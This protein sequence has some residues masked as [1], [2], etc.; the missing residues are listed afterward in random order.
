MKYM[1]LPS[2]FNI[3]PLIIRANVIDDDI[4]TAIFVGTKYEDMHEI[5]GFRD[6]SRAAAFI[7][8]LQAWSEVPDI[9]APENRELEITVKVKKL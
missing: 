1:V 9:C 8:E 6:P 2:E 5:T 3:G 4:V 7:Q